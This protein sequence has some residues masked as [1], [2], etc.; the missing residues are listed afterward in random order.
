MGTSSEVQDRPQPGTGVRALL[1]ELW[2]LRNT[3]VLLKSVHTALTCM[4]QWAGHPHAKQKGASSIPSQD[5]C[6]GCGFNPLYGHL[7][8][9]VFLSSFLPPFPIL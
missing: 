6:V 3:P 5:T 4:A 1:T 7:P 8:I 9:N 2:L